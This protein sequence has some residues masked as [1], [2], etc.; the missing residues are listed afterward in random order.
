MV[1]IP[2]GK[3]VKSHVVVSPGYLSKH[4]TPIKPADLF[5]HKTIGYRFSSSQQL[6]CWHFNKDDEQLSLQLPHKFIANSESVLLELA[7]LGQ[8]LA[9]VFEQDA[10]KQAIA[11]HELVCVLEDWQLEASQYY[12]YYPNRKFI[13]TKLKVFMDYFKIA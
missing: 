7:L 6:H 12:F 2:F 13:P 5:Q 8:G 1:A 3:P 10:V 9:Y 11:K 4:T